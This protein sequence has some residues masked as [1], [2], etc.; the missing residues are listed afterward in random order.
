MVTKPSS[1]SEYQNT[2]N[3]SSSQPLL[4]KQNSQEREKSRNREHE[5]D[6][7][8]SMTEVPKKPVHERLG[9]RPPA[10]REAQQQQRRTREDKQLFV[11]SFRRKDNDNERDREREREKEREREREHDRNREREREREREKEKERER[12]R[13]RDRDRERE[14]GRLPA[15]LRGRSEDR[16]KDRDLER[17]RERPRERGRERSRD[18]VENRRK[19]SVPRMRRS[20]SPIL[21]RT[22]TTNEPRTLPNITVS[23]IVKPNY[24]NKSIIA[25]KKLDEKMN[26]STSETSTDSEESSD[27]EENKVAHSPQTQRQRIGSR[28]IV[29]P[30][31]QVESS[32]DED[33]SL[34]SI[35]KIKPRA[36]VSPSKQAC[37]T[38]LLRA[39]AEA[40]RSTIIKARHKEE[41]AAP[42]KVSNIVQDPTDERKLYTKAYRE[43]LKRGAK[44]TSTSATSSNL[45]RRATQNLVIKVESDMPLQ[46]RRRAQ[47]DDVEVEEQA[48]SD[49]EELEE[50]EELEEKYVPG[51]VFQRVDS[52]INYMYVPQMIRI[53]NEEHESAESEE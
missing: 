31:K 9:I 27:D 4:Q 34:N 16:R 30:V 23:A 50:S 36:P 6:R 3:L 10:V 8:D 48:H 39:V 17:E 42:N 35:I 43:R 53:K 26:S 22:T 18:A 29:A 37:K 45:F 20:L 51:T 49:A 33:K 38:L 44:V 14:R 25:E 21:R 52:N 15:R 12:Q 47:I 19:G 11:P 5:R 40:Q 2:N 32:E 28:V 1:T 7:H 24:A 46:K 41:K 13:D